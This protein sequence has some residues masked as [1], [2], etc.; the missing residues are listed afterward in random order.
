MTVIYAF[1]DSITYGA[2]GIQTSGWA[3]LLRQY[4]DDL[5][6]KNSNYYGLFYNLG[7]PGETTT[8]LLNRFDNEVKAR[9]RVNDES[10]FIFAFGANDAVFLVSENKFRTSKDEF[11]NNLSIVFEKAR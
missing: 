8:G 9:I 10:V 7:I 4:L 2:W 5:Q 3:A 1:G 6:E 11:E